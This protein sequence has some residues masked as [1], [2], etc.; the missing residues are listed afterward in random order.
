MYNCKGFGLLLWLNPVNFCTE[1]PLQLQHRAVGLWV[2]RFRRFRGCGR[3]AGPNVEAVCGSGSA[4]S[5]KAD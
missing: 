1:Y 4:P 3:E 2:A 5:P